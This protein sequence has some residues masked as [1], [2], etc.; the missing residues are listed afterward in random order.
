LREHPFIINLI[1]ENTASTSTLYEAE[2]GPQKKI[3]KKF[4]MRVVKMKTMLQMFGK[5]IGW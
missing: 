2:S 1:F 4:M 5:V 3:V